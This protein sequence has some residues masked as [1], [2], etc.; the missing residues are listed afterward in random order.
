MSRDEREIKEKE[1]REDGEGWVSKVC[2]LSPM[3]KEMK[4][5]TERVE[6][7]PGPETFP[8]SQDIHTNR[9]Q[10]RLLNAGEDEDDC[11]I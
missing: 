3:N 4:R 9:W 5:R 1:I 11:L 7:E 10:R 6:R 2:S 8:H